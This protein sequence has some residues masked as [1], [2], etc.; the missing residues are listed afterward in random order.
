MPSLQRFKRMTGNP[1]VRPRRR[2]LQPAMS[3]REKLLVLLLWGQFTF[4]AVAMGGVDLWAEY[5]SLAIAAVSF[6]MLAMPLPGQS[7]EPEIRQPAAIVRS[8][9][10]FPP[11]WLGFALVVWI[12]ISS[13]NVEWVYTWRPGEARPRMV[14]QEAI[15]WLPS[16]IIAPLE[17]S[18]PYR[19]MISVIIPWLSLCVLW[20]G[21]QSRRALHL[22][23]NLIGVT[24][25]AW[26]IAALYQHYH[27]FEKILGIW[28]T[29]PR[30]QGTPIPFWGTLVNENHGA[31]FLVMGAGFCLAQFLGGFVRAARELRF[32]G[33]HLLYLGFAIILSFAAAQ[34]ESRGATS[35]T[36]VLWIG[37]IVVCSMFFIRFYGWKGVF[38]PAAVGTLFLIFVVISVSNPDRWERLKFDYEKTVSLSDNPELEGRYFMLMVCQDMIADRPWLGFGAGSFRYSHLRYIEP[39]RDLAPT[40]R[41]RVVDPDTGRRSWESRPFWFRQAHLDWLEFIIEWGFI[42]TIMVWL[43]W[44]WALGYLLVFRRFLDYGQVVMLWTGA[45]MI[46]SAAWEFHFRVLLVP[47]AWCLMMGMVIKS[48]SLRRR[49]MRAVSPD[50]PPVPAAHPPA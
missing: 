7:Y 11:F 21:I 19:G 17:Q 39:H 37:F 44:L 40:Y 42:G 33:W 1:G 36:I 25:L 20:A 24:L 9:L 31:F 49:S 16:G 35:M 29:H 10:C 26:G 32:G 30:K 13:W 45:V 38:L 15:P 3:G 12:W 22:L 43:A 18:N 48:V 47:L 28:E 2:R 41:V 8:L 34:A 50:Q 4:L 27:E 5:I 23:A 46:I 14:R 6:L